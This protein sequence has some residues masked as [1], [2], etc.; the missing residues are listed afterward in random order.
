M[1]IEFKLTDDRGKSYQGVAELGEVTGGRGPGTSHTANPTGPEV[2]GLPA[3]ILVLR[4]EGF[5]C[6]PRRPEEV[7]A[8][9]MESYYCELNRVQMALLRLHRKRCELNRSMQHHLIS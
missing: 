6:E 5:F 3:H 8:K 2:K 7:H 9:L 1:R 4:R